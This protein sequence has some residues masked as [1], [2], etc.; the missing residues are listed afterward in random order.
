[1]HMPANTIWKAMYIEV[2]QIFPKI[3]SRL[4]ISF[5]SLSDKKKQSDWRWWVTHQQMFA[6][7]LP[8]TETNPDATHFGIFVSL[9][10]ATF[11]SS[12]LNVVIDC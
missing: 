4:L 2:N 11:F 12:C 10:F 1:M 9:Q 3:T 5:D 7:N 6:Q 8:N